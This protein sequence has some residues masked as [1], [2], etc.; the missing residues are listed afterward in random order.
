M[1]QDFKVAGENAGF[2]LYRYVCVRL[3]HEII[4]PN[5]AAYQTL[6][7]CVYTLHAEISFGIGSLL[8]LNSI[9]RLYGRLVISRNE[10][11]T[12]NISYFSVLKTNF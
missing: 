6:Q 11:N 1:A 9:D 4:C 5:T 12:F 10:M 7:N 8:T 2:R 3:Y